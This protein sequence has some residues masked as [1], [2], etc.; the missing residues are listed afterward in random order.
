M[1]FQQLKNQI[2]EL[3]RSI[4]QETEPLYKVFI[5][6]TKDSS[7]EA[8]IQAYAVSHPHTHILKLTRKSFRNV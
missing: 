5:L 7:T 4:I 2:E 3:K 6:G 1:S 8:E